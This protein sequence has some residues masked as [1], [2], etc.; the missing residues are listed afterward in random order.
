MLLANTRA[1]GQLSAE[2][3]DTARARAVLLRIESRW[4]AAHDSATLSRILASD[5][6]HPVSSG[7]FLD[8]SQ[9]IA[10]VVAHPPD[11]S[12]DRRLADVRARF[13]GTTAIVTGT[14]IRSRDGSELGRNVF[15]DV[16]VKRD[17]RWLA[18]SA[19]ETTVARQDRKRQ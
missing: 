8:R 19:E 14:V 16:F 9:H 5:F 6:V 1:L 12:I 15:T 13:Y 17:G 10:W 4:L 11:S 2:R 18:V 3:V 7:Y